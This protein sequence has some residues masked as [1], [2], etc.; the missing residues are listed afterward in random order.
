MSYKTVAEITNKKRTTRFE[1][2]AKPQA[3]LWLFFAQVLT[4]LRVATR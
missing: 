4:S 3:E 1:K 2:N